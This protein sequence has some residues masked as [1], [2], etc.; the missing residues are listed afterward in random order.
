MNMTLSPEIQ[1]LIDARLKSGQYHTAED[2]VAAGL[3]C[4]GQQEHLG[5]FAPGELAQL[6]AVADAEIERGVVLDGE[7]VFREL[8]ALGNKQRG[9]AG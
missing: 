3:G 6:I 4:L 2:V 7:E 9:H 1:K 8:R 5:E